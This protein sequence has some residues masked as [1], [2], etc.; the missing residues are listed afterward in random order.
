MPVKSVF[1]KT[2]FLPAISAPEI[3]MR[4]TV[5]MRAAKLVET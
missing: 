4:L 5:S 2:G 3:G 1:K